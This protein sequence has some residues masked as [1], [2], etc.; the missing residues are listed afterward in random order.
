MR[1]IVPTVSPPTEMKLMIEMKVCF[2]FARRYFLA[3]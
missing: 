1:A 2:R 3:M